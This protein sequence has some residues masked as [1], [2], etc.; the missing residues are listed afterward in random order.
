MTGRSVRG[1]RA[2]ERAAVYEDAV[3]IDLRAGRN[4]GVGGIGRGVHA[5][6]AG[7][8]VAGT[9]P[10]IIGHQERRLRRLKL[11]QN[12]PDRRDILAVAVE[13]EE[14]RGRAYGRRMLRPYRTGRHVA[15]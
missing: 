5:R 7:P 10:G 14:P 8:A 15:Y 3:G 1:R 6:L 9:I 13:P 11:P 12:R 2:A 4:G